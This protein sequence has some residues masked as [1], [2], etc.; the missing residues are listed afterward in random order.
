MGA[1][2]VGLT[3]FNGLYP[4]KPL[5]VSGAGVTRVG[6]DLASAQLSDPPS[7]V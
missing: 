6:R 5:A 4:L 7:A 1:G 2:Y 3:L